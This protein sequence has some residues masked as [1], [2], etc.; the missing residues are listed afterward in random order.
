MSIFDYIFTE[1]KPA[2]TG[3]YFLLRLSHVEHHSSP[4]LPAR[5]P[6]PWQALW[7]LLIPPRK[8]LRV[9]LVKTFAQKS[10]SQNRKIS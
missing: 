3:E 1:I 9:L 8:T 4:C 10:E 7:Q 5:T 2:L 6:I